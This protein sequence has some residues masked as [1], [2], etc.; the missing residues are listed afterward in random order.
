MRSATGPSTST[1]TAAWTTTKEDA[2][3]SRTIDTPPAELRKLVPKLTREIEELERLRAE[4]AA[5]LAA[6]DEA[7]R[8]VKGAE[9]ADR[10]AVADH[11]RGR[12]KQEP[13]PS[14]PKA[15]QAVALAEARAAGLDQATTDAQADLETAIEKHRKEYA[16]KL[17]H[18]SE[19]GRERSGRRQ[20][21][22]PASRLTGRNCS[23]SVAGSTKVVTRRASPAPQRSTCGA[24]AA[25]R[26]PSARS[27][28]LSRVPSRRRSSG[29]SPN[30]G[31]CCGH[32]VTPCNGWELGT[33]GLCLRRGLGARG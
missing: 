10:Q 1:S 24:R 23:L 19:Q 26:T 33:A 13:K 15:H 20:R 17:D 14:V 8:V 11:A 4:A 27:C 22:W 2:M 3:H 32:A 29:R 16:T 21:S 7:H 5:A 18:Q 12:L 30:P 6:L 9:E 31:R 28:R 25:S